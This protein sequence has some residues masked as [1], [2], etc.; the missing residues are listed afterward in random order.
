MIDFLLSKSVGL[1]LLH[2]S[3]HERENVPDGTC[4]SEHS[5]FE[6][7]DGFEVV[8]SSDGRYAIIQEDSGN[9]YGQC[10]GWR[11]VTLSVWG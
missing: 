10:L 11:R 2:T 4:S 6:D 3:L 5:T 9:D 1:N 7:I 8:A